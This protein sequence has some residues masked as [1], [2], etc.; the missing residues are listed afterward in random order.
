MRDMLGEDYD[1]F[2]QAAALP[3]Y[4]GIRANTL[5]LSSDELKSRLNIEMTPSPFCE[6]GYYIP[7]DTE[8]LGNHPFHHAGAFYIQ[9]PSATSAV[10]AMEIKPGDTVLDLCAAPGGK[11]TQIA[12]AL[13]GKG[14]LWSNEFVRSRVQS[15]ISN[16]ERLGVTN[17]AV[18]SM[19]PDE[20]CPM[21]E[22]A[23]DKVL[24]D[25]PC[26]GEGMFRK[27]PKALENWSLE[28]S[29]SCGDRQVKILASAAYAVK[30]GGL[31][32]Y[33]T[34]TFSYHENEEVVA[35]FL[36]LRPEFELV[37]IK[38]DFG[39]PG[40][41]KY[42]PDTVGIEHTR[43]IF[44]FNGGE[45]HFVALMR[46]SGD[47]T[48]E[49]L[50]DTSVQKNEAVRAF[51]EFEAD[52]FMM[53]LKGI[54]YSVRDKVYITPLLPSIGGKALIRNG[55]LCGEYLG[56]RFEPSH[57]LFSAFGGL[58]RNRVDF[59]LS[60]D[61][62]YRFLHGEELDCDATLK[63]YTAVLIEGVPLSF[64]KTSGGRLKNRYPK[65]LRT[66]K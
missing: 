3:P 24:V 31:L 7:S 30:S 4:R 62:I 58:A 54:K 16:I 56:K 60:E 50:S 14:Y 46:K 38:R 40:Y 39:E 37:P 8:G 6:L 52:C 15:L 61:R 13:D 64:A 18:S 17:A 32:C 9:E 26:S 47:S 41:K 29:I 10:E 11:S 59:S 21:L 22:G 42:A 34:C 27:E 57:A 44:P 5:K 2:E 48:S 1:S 19:R 35:R 23:F 12:A 45:G 53:P 49:L 28:N 36:K 65:G 43:H 33:S 51:E 63:G 20:L 25:A 66:L 55:V